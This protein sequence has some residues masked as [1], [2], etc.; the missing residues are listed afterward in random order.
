[1]L[2][3]M[4]LGNEYHVNW[5]SDCIEHLRRTD[6]TCVEA[7]LP[8]EEG[9][10]RHVNEVGSATLFPQANS[11]YLG[12]NVPGKPRTILPYLG[13]FRAYSQRCDEVAAKGYEGFSLS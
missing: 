7:T 6:R 4:V 8:A 2:F 1:V 13:G 3:N 11:W 9:W 5:I 10:G 12:V